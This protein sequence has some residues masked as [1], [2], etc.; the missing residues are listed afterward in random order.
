LSSSALTDI[1]LKWAQPRPLVYLK[2]Y[3]W[4]SI[5]DVSKLC[6]ANATVL[7]LGCGEGLLTEQFPRSM[8][9][10]GVELAVK[11]L[12][13][14]KTHSH[15]RAW[16]A[17]DGRMLP[18]KGNE[19]DAVVMHQVIEHFSTPDVLLREV[20]RTLK[21]GG[22]LLLS[23]PVSEPIGRHFARSRNVRGERTLSDDHL[24]EF[25]SVSDLTNYVKTA[26]RSELSL[27]QFTKK[28]VVFPLSRLLPFLKTNGNNQIFLPLW[29]YYSD[30][31]AIFR[32][33]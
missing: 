9:L 25:R 10:V 27:V 23:T 4:N 17:T 13:Y 15:G 2:W 29:F 19:V 21:R 31:Y 11:R 28:Y 5:D 24:H 33:G 1:P 26:T 20:S 16:L 7:D 8:T 30:I 18:V 22:Y 14:A 12:L 32:K 3:H 6:S